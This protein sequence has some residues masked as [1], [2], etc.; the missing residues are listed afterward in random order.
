MC[1]FI[2]FYK[3][4]INHVQID[5]TCIPDPLSPNGDVKCSCTQPDIEISRYSYKGEFCTELV[6][7]CIDP[8]TALVFCEG[9]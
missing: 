8:D 9:F 2:T 7:A 5:A 1:I 3:I 4:F 6:D